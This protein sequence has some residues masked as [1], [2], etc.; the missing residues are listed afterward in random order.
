M[1]ASAAIA[2]PATRIMLSVQNAGLVGVWDA[3][4]AF[5]GRCREAFQAVASALNPLID[6]DSCSLVGTASRD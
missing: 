6:T 1:P 3:N 4:E 5:R 2:S